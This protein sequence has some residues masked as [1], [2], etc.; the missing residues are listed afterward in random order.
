MLAEFPGVLTYREALIARVIDPDDFGEVDRFSGA[1][2]GLVAAGLV[3]RQ[4]ELLLPTRPARQMVGLG[5][6]LG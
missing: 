6:I 2:H 4:G 1:V 5:F 3:V